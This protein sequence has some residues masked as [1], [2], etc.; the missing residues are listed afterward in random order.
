MVDVYYNLQTKLFSNILHNQKKHWSKGWCLK[1]FLISTKF[2]FPNKNFNRHQFCI[3]KTQ[4]TLLFFGF[5]FIFSVIEIQSSEISYKSCIG[6]QKKTKK[7]KFILLTFNFTFFLL[8]LSKKKHCHF[9][10]KFELICSIWN[11]NNKLLPS[12]KT[13]L[14]IF[15]AKKNINFFWIKFFLLFC[16]IFFIF[17]C[18]FLFVYFVIYFSFRC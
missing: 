13:L 10:M 8:L 3:L 6:K 18:L 1:T 9:K 15:V 4:E 14:T 11:E 7:S 12:Y 2:D 16:N 5:I 17:V